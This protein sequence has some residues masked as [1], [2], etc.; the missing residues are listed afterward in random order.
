MVSIR[1]KRDAVDTF[2][3]ATNFRDQNRKRYMD[4]LGTKENLM[5]NPV[6]L[7][8]RKGKRP[9]TIRGPLHVQCSENDDDRA[10][11][12]LVE[13]IL[14]WP[15]IE[16]GPLP[17]GSANLVSLNVAAQVASGDPF[18][19]ITGREFA[20]VLFGAPTIYLTLP[21]SSAHWAIVRGW[22][23]PHFSGSFGLVPPG[24]MVVYTPRDEYELSVCRSLF[25]VS[26]NFSRIAARRE[27]DEWDG[28]FESLSSSRSS[29]RT[30][31]CAKARPA[32]LSS[33]L[34]PAGTAMR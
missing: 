18:A 10:I 11:R 21:L 17:V 5:I 4:G 15:H 26:Y 22:A 19:F 16:A 32:V 29:Y 25:W 13:E 33:P 23:E 24:V 20:R 28:H 6:N 34:A 3:P 2:T 9:L 31:G 1:D 12:C 8:S 7:P 27:S 14:A 30:D